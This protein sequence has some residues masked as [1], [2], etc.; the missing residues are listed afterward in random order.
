MIINITLHN[1]VAADDCLDAIKEYLIAMVESWNNSHHHAGIISIVKSFDDSKESKYL[2]LR[3]PS[4]IDSGV[5]TSSST[6]SLHYTSSPFKESPLVTASSPFPPCPK[7]GR[8]HKRSL[9]HFYKTPLE[10]IHRTTVACLMPPGKVDNPSPHTS[11]HQLTGHHE[12]QINHPIVSYTRRSY[13][14]PVL[15]DPIQQRTI[16]TLHR[17]ATW[18]YPMEIQG[19]STKC[20]KPSD[21]QTSITDHIP[22]L[23]RRSRT[24]VHRPIYPPPL[25][26]R[27]YS[28]LASSSMDTTTLSRFSPSLDDFNED[29]KEDTYEDA[30]HCIIGVLD[31]ITPKQH[32]H[33]E[34][35]P[36][37]EATQRHIEGQPNIGK[38]Q[39]KLWKRNNIL[40]KGKHLSVHKQ[41]LTHSSDASSDDSDTPKNK[42]KPQ[43]RVSSYHPLRRT[44]VVNP[45]RRKTTDALP[46]LDLQVEKANLRTANAE[47]PSSLPDQKSVNLH[48]ACIA[49][50]S[51]GDNEESEHNSGKYSIVR[52]IYR[53][54]EIFI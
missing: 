15:G 40:R 45:T 32:K 52:H 43:R 26:L 21:N 31:Q 4:I 36:K 53:F 49:A 50:A 7:T 46:S 51:E 11:N 47:Q 39:K 3:R 19:S 24:V 12:T 1:A 34:T 41:S 14:Q 48:N 8:S 30:E 2:S 6:S 20:Y 54:G 28:D 44:S 38:L 33:I 42:L 25:P 37:S 13:V 10:R 5:S 22:T 29:D 16:G 23:P 35:D 17:L 9:Q 27:R 18:P